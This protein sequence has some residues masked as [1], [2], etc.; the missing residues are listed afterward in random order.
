MKSGEA[1]VLVI[2][3][4]ARFFPIWH[5]IVRTD[6]TFALVLRPFYMHIRQWIIDQHIPKDVHA[7]CIQHVSVNL[8]SGA[9]DTHRQ[10]QYLH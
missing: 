6:Q 3:Y 7:I 2:K 8:P 4:S 5:R 1:P 10:Y 9:V